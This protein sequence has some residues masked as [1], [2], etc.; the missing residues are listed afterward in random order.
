MKIIEFLPSLI[1]RLFCDPK[2]C[3]GIKAC[4]QID[5]DSDIG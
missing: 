1:M 3:A 2:I 5:F 4:D